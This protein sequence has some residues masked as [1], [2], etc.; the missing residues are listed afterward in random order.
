MT[1]PEAME[2]FAFLYSGGNLATQIYTQLLALSPSDCPRE[3]FFKPS[4]ERVDNP[5]P[6]YADV[7]NPPRVARSCVSKYLP[8]ILAK[9]GENMPGLQDFL[10]R[11]DAKTASTFVDNM[12]EASR[13]SYSDDG[14]VEYSEISVV[15]VVT[16]YEETLMTRYDLNYDD[17]LQSNELFSLGTPPDSWSDS[18]FLPPVPGKGCSDSTCSAQAW[19]RRPKPKATTPPPPTAEDVFAGFIQHYSSEIAGTTLSEADSRG[20]FRYI[21]TNKAVPPGGLVGLA[22]VNLHWY[23]PSSPTLNRESLSEIFRLIIGRLINAPASSGAAPAAAD[24]H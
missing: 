6:E 7:L 9:T 10:T 1:F 22:E 15:A 5:G 13:A 4:G 17:L 8:T 12:I 23:W 16:Q 19:I 2:Y 21:V 14:W 3:P 11:A 24:C 18:A 20:A